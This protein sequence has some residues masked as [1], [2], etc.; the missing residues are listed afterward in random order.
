MGLLF[1]LT[2]SW[3]APVALLAV[4]VIPRMLAGWLVSTPRFVED[5]VAK[6]AAKPT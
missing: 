5:D 6:R 4:L 1:D 3:T 2:G